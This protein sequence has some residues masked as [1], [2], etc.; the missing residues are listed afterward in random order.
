MQ[1]TKT[2][3]I[4]ETQFVGLFKHNTNYKDKPWDW[5]NLLRQMLKKKIYLVPEEPQT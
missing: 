5:N 1:N 4:T 3:R 2:M